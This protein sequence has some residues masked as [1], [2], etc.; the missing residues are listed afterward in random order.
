M[1]KSSIILILFNSLLFS[2][3]YG[4]ISGRIVNKETHQPIEGVNIV[5]INTS[6][7]TASDSNGNFSINKIPVGSYT[8]QINMIGFL[9]IMRPNVNITTDKNT[10][11]NFYLEQSVIEGQAIYVNEGYFEKTQDAVVSNRTMDYEEIRSD[12]IGVYDIQMMM[13]ALPAV[14]SE[15]DQSNEIIVRGGDAGENLFIMDNI[16]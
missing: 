5:V 6:I 10:Q 3:F 16:E 1:F 13:Q 8:L 4:T 11:L 7:G 12:P 14:V 9:P 15:S 2:Q